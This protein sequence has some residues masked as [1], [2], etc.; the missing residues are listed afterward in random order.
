[1][2]RLQQFFQNALMIKPIVAFELYINYL[3]DDLYDVST[4]NAHE[5]KNHMLRLY[6]KENNFTPVV[7]LIIT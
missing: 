2:Q 5:F 3:E 7:K 1:M 4:I 6:D